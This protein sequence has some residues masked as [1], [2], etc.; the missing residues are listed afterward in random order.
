MLALS[1]LAS[2]SLVL[3]SRPASSVARSRDV[4]MGPR[5]D[6]ILTGEAVPPEALAALGVEG[7]RAVVAFFCRDNGFECGKELADF[8]ERSPS[9]A[10]LDC[11]IVAIRSEG[12]WV[13]E[14]TAAKYPSLR[15]L[16]DKD[17][18]LRKA[19]RMN[20]GNTQRDRHTFLLDTR[21]VVQGQVNIYQDPFVHSA[22]AIRTVKTM[23][24]PV[25]PYDAATTLD[26]ELATKYKGMYEAEVAALE[27]REAELQ[28]AKAAREASGG[29]TDLRYADD[30]GGGN[31]FEN[32]FGGFKKE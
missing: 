18:T 28:A 13:T 8:Q 31:F 30:G 23:D 11:D 6:G 16:V 24:D 21:G 32:L 2:A 9:Y 1:Y 5:S 19:F 4:L 25:K 20:L 10:A 12:P 14:E 22:M 3:P 17:E 27:K 15:F 29:S 26:P 7:R